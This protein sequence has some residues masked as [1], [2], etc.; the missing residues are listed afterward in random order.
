MAKA[1]SLRMASWSRTIHLLTMTCLRRTQ[2]LGRLAHYDEVTNYFFTFIGCVVGTNKRGITL[3]K[4]L[5][6]QTNVF[7]RWLTWNC[8]ISPP[9]L[10]VSTPWRRRKHSRDHSRK[11]S[12]P[13]KK[14][15][16][17]SNT[18]HSWWVLN[19]SFCSGGKIRLK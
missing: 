14:V 12:L 17:A 7:W 9:T 2:S 6:V 11:T 15:L 18:L 3:W 13:R 10:F 1:T 16:N 4:F 19:K 8:L 5:L